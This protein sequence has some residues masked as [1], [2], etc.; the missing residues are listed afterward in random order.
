MSIFRYGSLINHADLHPEYVGVYRFWLSEWQLH[1]ELPFR[2]EP[3]P[4]PPP[5]DE[6]SA[7]P[8]V[9][10]IIGIATRRALDI[11][12]VVRV[13]TFVD[14]SKLER[15]KMVAELL[16]NNGKIISAATVYKLP[17]IASTDFD[18]DDGRGRYNTQDDPDGFVIKSY[19][20]NLAKGKELRIVDSE[21][22][23]VL[24]S[25]K[26]PEYSPEVIQFDASVNREGGLDVTCGILSAIKQPELWVRWSSN[27]GKRWHPIKTK[28]ELDERS[29][30]YQQY[31]L[32]LTNVPAGKVLLQLVVN[33]GFF[34]TISESVTI[35]PP[36][37]PYAV[38]LLHPKNGQLLAARRRIHL[39]AVVNNNTG[40]HADHA[41]CSWIID[42]KEVA[43]GSEAW[44]TTPPPG[45]HTCVL[46]VDVD[47][48]TYERKVEFET[49]LVGGKNK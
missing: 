1:E 36:E 28:L 42:G 32:P 3:G 4:P 10:S 45:I 20:P 33:D 7:M 19:I 39:W 9:I 34:T 29:E 25:R 14:T 24:W 2:K 18:R 26:A 23:T 43:D 11:R 17:Q 30:K 13:P 44:I 48:N 16:D 49:V 38:S 12:T 35:S 15:T 47:E 40:K 8:D 46:K 41:K 37:Q 21:D 6:K 22:H 27:H 5:F 31:Q